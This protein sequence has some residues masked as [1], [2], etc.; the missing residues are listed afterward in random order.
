[1]KI[2]KLNYYKNNLNK[3]IINNKIKINK[4]NKIFIQIKFNVKI[5]EIKK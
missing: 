3:L 1:M 4:K 2:N 5:Y